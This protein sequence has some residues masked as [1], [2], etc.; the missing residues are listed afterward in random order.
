MRSGIVLSIAALLAC[1]SATGQAPA[2]FGSVMGII[3]DRAGNGMPDARVVLSNE[4][5]GTERTLVS[6][7]DGVF[8]AHNVVP[9]EGYRITITRKDFAGWES[10]LFP[11]STGQKQT[12]EIVLQ[13]EESPDSGVKAESTG[14]MRPVPDYN[15]GAG[16]VNTAE[17]VENTPNS[18]RTM[19]TL[20]PLAPFAV[21]AGATPGVM[22]FHGVPFSN[23]L[24]I[25][26]IY[27]TDNYFFNRP[28]TPDPVSLAA[29]Q[30]FYTASSNFT[31][32]FGN[33][34]G[35]LLDAATHSSADAYH[36]SIYEYFRN[37]AWQ[38]HDRYAMGFD[39]RQRQNQ[40]GISVGGPIR[41]EN[42]FFFLN[43]EGL[44]RSGE[45]LNRITNPLIA[46]PTGTRV[47]PSNCQATAAQCFVA[48]RFLKSQMNVLTPLWEH[49]YHGL[50]KIDYRRSARNNVSLEAGGLQ[51]HAPSLAETETVAANG[52]LL[53]DPLMLEQTRFAKIGWTFT[54]T[55][56]MTN[57]MRAGF[58]Q[59]RI[60]QGVS[61]MPAGFATGLLGIQIAGTTV[62][63]PQSST[64]V[65]PS[66]HRLEFVDIATWT[67]G[68][69]TLKAGAEI[70]RNA[71]YLNSLASAAGLYQ[72][73]SLT[74][75]AEDFA[76]TGQRNYTNFT[77]TFGNPVRNLHMRQL[78]AFVEDVY[79]ATPRL[80]MSYG[81]RYE[82]PR[83]PQPTETNTTFF[84]TSSITSPWLDLSPR[85]GFAYQ[86]SSKTVIRA[87]FGFF[88]APFSGELV[89]SLFLGNGLYQTNISV[90]PSLT[91]APV[92]PQVVASAS[93]IPNGSLNVAYSTTKFSNPYA[94]ELNVALERY[95]GAGTTITLNLLH[96]R[97]YKLWTTLDFNQL[98][99][100]STQAITETYN[101]NNAAGAQVNTYTTTDF[102]VS[103]NNA[104]FAH[105]YQIENGGASWYNAGSLQVRKRMA[106][107]FGLEGTYTFSH[108]LDNTGQNAPFGGGFSST[109][110]GDYADDRGNSAFDQRHHLT[111]QLL[112]QPSVG[113]KSSDFARRILNGWRLSTFA[114]LASSQPATPI[115]EVQGQQFSGVTMNYTS[116]L[117]G[118]DGWARVPFLPINSLQ[119]GPEYN[120]DASFGRQLT[121]TERVKAVLAFEGFNVFNMQYNTS[122]NTIA[123]RSQAVLPPGLLNGTQVGTLFPVPGVGAGNA[124]QSFPDGTNARRLQVAVRI[125][126]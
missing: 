125:V 54:T 34:M 37:N 119:T 90:T 24:L 64:V 94:Q 14:S 48:T 81:L 95:L 18:G 75:F 76:L 41:G 56:Q 115:V 42:L 29:V 67:L 65:L 77:Q 63:A 19:E 74:Y 108:A 109:V 124:A 69:H 16:N 13:A 117:N 45:G 7:D 59:D 43:L 12:F 106:H 91:G 38:A 26:G 57:D 103:K 11:V 84:Q 123:Y 110:N 2:G 97:G 35:G 85:A 3:L 116:T 66:E 89:D 102:I 36:G 122:V 20:S 15:N 114:T 50:I 68:S 73:S 78:N 88:Y 8:D 1:G 25:D 118:S 58:Y 61:S 98:N 39:T 126:F 120:V 51:W 112:W 83:L 104:S 47:L 5:L 107:G 49:S 87:G 105:V 70:F 71:D 93:K 121:I 82:K 53:G 111:V 6:T 22:V 86:L 10:E 31:A 60:T 28:A 4:S 52:G 101:I 62:G 17:M 32:E 99:P 113:N 33:T 27:A 30:D 72:Y 21:L 96:V 44:D 55:G 79:K 92:F 23:P 46:D 80:T 40:G 100:S 9:A